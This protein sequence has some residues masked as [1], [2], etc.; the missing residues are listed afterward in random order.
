MVTV[1][2][3]KE[4][5]GFDDSMVAFIIAFYGIMDPIATSGNVCANNFFVIMFQKIRTL[6]KKQV[7]L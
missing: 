6:V 7:S 2:V 5:L 4:Y 3:L 1:P